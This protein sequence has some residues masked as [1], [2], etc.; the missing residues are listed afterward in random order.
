[1]EEPLG[2]GLRNGKGRY[3]SAGKVRE[4]S[5]SHAYRGVVKVG[6]KIY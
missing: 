4:W 5:I 2:L 3:C 1:M 6:F